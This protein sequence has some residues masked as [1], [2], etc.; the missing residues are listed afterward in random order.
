MLLIFVYA[1]RGGRSAPLYNPCIVIFRRKVKDLP[2]VQGLLLQGRVSKDL[3][4]FSYIQEHGP[5]SFFILAFLIRA[6]KT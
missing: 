6:T 5:R 3:F 1:L 2:A 4:L